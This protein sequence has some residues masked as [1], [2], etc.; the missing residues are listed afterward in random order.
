MSELRIYLFHPFDI[1]STHTTSHLLHTQTTATTNNVVSRAVFLA[2]PP[3]AS[4]VPNNIINALITSH[5]L[6]L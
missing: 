5:I 1:S 3:L 6:N 4:I 2:S